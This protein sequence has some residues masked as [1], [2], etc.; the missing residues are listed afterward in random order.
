M[1]SPPGSS[2]LH[3]RAK[4]RRR[5]AGVIGI[6]VIA[7][8]L[9]LVFLLSSLYYDATVTKSIRISMLPSYAISSIT[10]GSDYSD[11]SLYPE[12]FQRL[13]REHE[14]QEP[15]LQQLDPSSWTPAMRS[16]MRHRFQRHNRESI[17]SLMLPNDFGSKVEMTRE[18]TLDTLML[19][20]KDRPFGYVHEHIRKRHKQGLYETRDLSGRDIDNDEEKKAY[21]VNP[22][23]LW[24]AWG[25]TPGVPQKPRI[26][27]EDNIC[28]AFQNANNIANFSTPHV[29]IT[30]LN[31]NWGTLSTMV[32][33]R[34]AEWGDLLNTFD[35]DCKAT[36]IKELYLD[37]P[38]TLAVFTVQHQSIFDH[39]KTHSIPIGIA[40]SLDGGQ[41]RIRLLQD[42]MAME[43]ITNSSETLGKTNQSD[44]RPQLLMINNSPH[45]RRLPQINAV[46]ENFAKEGIKVVN[47]FN[48]D[49]GEKEYL[50]KFYNEL[51][52]SKFILCPSGMGWDSYR[53][54]EALLMGAIPVI[55]RHKYRYEVLTYPTDS[56]KRPLILRMLDE[57]ETGGDL[58]A[59]RK[60]E[61]GRKKFEDVLT[62][63]HIHKYNA[64]IEVVEYYDGWRKSLDDLPVVWIDGKFEDVAPPDEENS[65]NYLTPQLLEREYDAMAARMETFRYEK[66]TSLYWLRFIESFLLLNDPTEA[67]DIHGPQRFDSWSEMETWHLAMENLSPTFNNHSFLPGRRGRGWYGWKADEEIMIEGGTIDGAENEEVIELNDYLFGSEQ[68]RV[69]SWI[70]LIQL[71]LMGLALV[72]VAWTKFAATS[73]QLD[74]M[75]SKIDA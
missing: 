27:S 63:E 57:G 20:G 30:H 28:R 41:K 32:L 24:A 60:S 31:E 47:S 39:P 67:F 55:E 4:K 13:Y 21:K 25:N 15:E 46:I 11:L 50:G 44:R 34:T 3:D 18:P 54:W 8:F 33:N 19:W 12:P 5:R 73:A 9:A 75:Q 58:G 45:K 69:L 17:Y 26:I 1:S 56:G 59:T 61:R 43:G 49:G 35:H 64:S 38:N 23:V 62:D 10:G 16:E 68:P 51:S 52:F 2:S 74:G 7:S 42:R 6:R 48:T 72:I 37:S 70:V 14:A 65:K 53:I 66:L 40:N 71:K 22:N 36:D 29:L